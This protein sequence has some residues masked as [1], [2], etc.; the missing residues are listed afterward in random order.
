[1]KTAANDGGGG[2]SGDKSTTGTTTSS[3]TTMQL[4]LTF[5]LYASLDEVVGAESPVLSTL[6]ATLGGDQLL[7][8]RKEEKQYEY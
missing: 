2:G 8:V 5:P 6:A 3:S 1:L 7:K 4:P